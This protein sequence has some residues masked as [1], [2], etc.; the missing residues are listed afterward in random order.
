MYPGETQKLFDLSYGDF[1]ATTAGMTEDFEDN[2]IAFT[3]KDDQGKVYDTAYFASNVTVRVAK[4]SVATT[5]GTAYFED[6]FISNLAELDDDLNGLA[7]N[8]ANTNFG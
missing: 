5:A 8:D 7:E 3:V 1:T 2:V 4:P 6:S